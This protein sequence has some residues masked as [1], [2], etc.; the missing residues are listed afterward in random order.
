MKALIIAKKI[1]IEAWREPQFSLIYLLFPALM[2][3]IFFYAYGNPSLSTILIVLVDNQDQGAL[4]AEFVEMLKAETYDGKPVY[5]IQPSTN[6]AI[7]E[8]FIGE[9]KAALLMIIPPDFSERVQ[10]A[11]VSPLAPS[12]LLNFIGDPGS[13]MYM[14]AQG[15]LVASATAFSGQGSAAAGAPQAELQFL[16][17]TGTLTDFQF[18]IPGVLAFG[19]LFGAITSAMVV[20]RDDVSGVSRRLRLTRLTSLDV[21]LGVV[22]G[23]AAEAFIQL[24]LSLLVAFLL[25]LKVQGSIALIFLACFLLSLCATGL[26]FLSAC[27][28]KNDGEA[29]NIATGF[30]VPLVFL[31]GTLFPMPAVP[32][33]KIGSQVISLYDVFPTSHA[34]EVMRRVMFYGDGFFQ[35]LYPFAMLTIISVLILAAG[36]WLYQRR[37]AIQ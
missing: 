17:G 26:G 28:A 15:F 4:S 24:P 3:W 25:G 22:L 29:A 23:L 33:G 19:I 14:F 34:S 11:R 32:I 7:S 9:R 27:F 10:T 6:R 20:V 8:Q 13:D 5:T 30:M 16:P 31:S 21:V 2:I 37:R 1:L 12:A 35:L 18:G 36:V